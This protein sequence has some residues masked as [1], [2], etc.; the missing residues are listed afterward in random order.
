MTDLIGCMVE[1][2]GW[3]GRVRAVTS[4]SAGRMYL[5]VENEWRELRSVNASSSRVLDDGHF[6]MPEPEPDVDGE[7]MA[8]SVSDI[9][10]DELRGKSWAELKGAMFVPV[11]QTP[12]DRADG[13]HRYRMVDT[14]TRNDA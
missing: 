7:P 2:E 3:K 8:Y 11:E 1:G 13:I 6:Q 12:D 4:D 9:I 14:G 10:P 5:W